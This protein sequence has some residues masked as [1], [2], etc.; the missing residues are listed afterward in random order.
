MMLKS[1]N[2]YVLEM[3]KIKFTDDEYI[4]FIYNLCQKFT[5]DKGTKI[6]LRNNIF[7]D[8]VYYLNHHTLDSFKHTYL[9]MDI[10][11]GKF[12][13]QDA[14]INVILD[15]KINGLEF[16][17][18]YL[19]YTIRNEI[20]IER[21]SNGHERFELPFNLINIYDFICSDSTDIFNSIKASEPFEIAEKVYGFK[22]LENLK[23]EIGTR[24]YGLSKNLNFSHNNLSRS[25]R[26]H[27]L[28]YLIKNNIDSCIAYLKYKKNEVQFEI[29]KF[30]NVS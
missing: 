18:S 12:N 7:N 28:N 21:I 1:F 24:I 10:N 25:Q 29:C 4:E 14:V 5:N 15:K 30:A 13:I 20:L 6:Y 3:A 11:R 8:D 27:I 17:L 9:S 22:K 19:I 2:K 26:E 23:L 16:A